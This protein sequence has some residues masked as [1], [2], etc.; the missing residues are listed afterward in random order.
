M[1]E[2]I[3]KVLTSMDVEKD[4]ENDEY[5]DKIVMVDVLA[6]LYRMIDRDS[7]QKDALAYIYEVN[8]QL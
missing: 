4:K 7:K 8:K 2:P 6:K 3:I 5:V 1:P